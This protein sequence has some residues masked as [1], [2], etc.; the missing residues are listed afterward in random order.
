MTVDHSI[1]LDQA[2]IQAVLEAVLGKHG[3]STDRSRLCAKLFIETTLDGVYSHGLNRFPV[4]LEMVS[5]GY[6]K[7]DNEPALVHALH[8]F[9]SWDGNLGPGNLNAWASMGRAIE[10]ARASGVGVVSL[11][12]TNHWM[13]GGSYGLQAAEAGCI[14]ICMT[15]TKPNMPPWG[16]RETA[17]GNNPFVIAVPNEPYPVLLDMAMSQFSYGKMEVLQQRGKR[18]PFAG[19]FDQDLQLTDDPDAIIDSELALPMGYWKG[20]GMAVMVDLLVAILSGGQTT[21]EIGETEV[22]YGLSQ[23]FMAF[24]LQQ[25]SDDDNRKRVLQQIKGSLM[26]IAPMTAVS[27]VFYP[28]QQTWL[29]RQENLQKGI[30]VDRALWNLITS[31]AS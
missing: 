3:F 29:R 7:P 16:G 4:F 31:A 18:L 17:V 25:L 8:G 22:E 24:D 30:P 14:G 12:N 6:V 9:E 26:G 5:K 20:S 21:P 1:R 13:R 15:N 10:L 19:G 27:Q 11:R 2:E 23:L 28:G